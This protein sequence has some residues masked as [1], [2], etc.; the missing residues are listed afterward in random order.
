MKG[1]ELTTVAFQEELP[2]FE[3][4]GFIRAPKTLGTFAVEGFE[5]DGSLNNDEFDGITDYVIGDLVLFRGALLFDDDEDEYVS[6]PELDGV[7]RV[8]DLGHTHQNPL[9]ERAVSMGGGPALIEVLEG[10]YFAGTFW[11]NLT[12][13]TG[14]VADESAVI[15][16]Q[17]EPS[18]S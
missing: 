1:L 2:T 15:L 5:I 9:L 16:E 10:T 12:L 18:E 14:Y 3:V 8:T 13:P 17:F 4:K 11:K 7:Y 6:A